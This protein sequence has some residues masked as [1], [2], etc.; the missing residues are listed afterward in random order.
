[1]TSVIIRFEEL[2]PAA[3]A[4][5]RSVRKACVCRHRKANAEPEAFYVSH[6][7]ETTVFKQRNGVW[8]AVKTY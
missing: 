2:P 5:F 1:M 3:Q 4:V 8:T 6:G 7:G